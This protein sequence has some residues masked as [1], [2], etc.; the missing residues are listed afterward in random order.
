M[1]TICIGCHA[2]ISLPQRENDSNTGIRVLQFTTFCLFVVSIF[3]LIG[4]LVN[5][6]EMIYF[7]VSFFF[8]HLSSLMSSDITRLQI[9]FLFLGFFSLLVTYFQKWRWGT[10]QEIRFESE[11]LPETLD[12]LTDLSRTGKDLTLNIKKS[13]HCDSLPTE[14]DFD[15]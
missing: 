9:L 7:A 14:D 5:D 10:A 12:I 13:R 3:F 6:K 11:H 15:V 2:N 8:F 1:S 4:S